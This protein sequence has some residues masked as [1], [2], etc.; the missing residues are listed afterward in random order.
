DQFF[1]G[2]IGV[3]NAGKSTIIKR[4]FDVET[5]PDLVLRTEKVQ[6]YRLGDWMRRLSDH[7]E[8][9]RDWR[10][11][12]DREN[13]QVYAVDYPGTTDEREKVAAITRFTAE[14]ASFFVVMLKAGHLAGP[15]KAV[16]QIAV[17]SHMPFVV[18]INHCDSIVDEFVKNG[19]ARLRQSY[20]E[21][22]GIPGSYIHFMSAISANSVYFDNS[23]DAFR[24]VLYLFLQ[25][26]IGD[27][28]INDALA[29]RLISHRVISELGEDEEIAFCMPEYVGKAAM[30]LMSNY[31]PVSA[32]GIM[33]L[34]QK[35]REY[36]NDALH[37]SGIGLDVYGPQSALLAIDQLRQL[38]SNL[39]IE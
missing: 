3:H 8:V 28:L 25:N 31:R 37:S 20:A 35:F 17:D 18:V 5:K 10:G 39:R 4:L 38:A 1:I 30:S 12:H 22:L 33:L 16:V 13:L 32:P 2:F 29:M 26:M 21:S 23:V 19:E 14:L 27:P 15:E 7:H 11:E 6:Q 36:Y 9:F 34:W 24:G